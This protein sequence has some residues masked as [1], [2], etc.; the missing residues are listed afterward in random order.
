MK[1]KKKKSKFDFS[2][3]DWL[4]QLMCFLSALTGLGGAVD[5]HQVFFMNAT[6]T[7]SSNLFNIIEA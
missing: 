1:Q 4:G 3:L 2:L 5:C 7:W 6:T